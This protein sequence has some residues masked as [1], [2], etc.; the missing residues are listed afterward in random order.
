V[1]FF[2]KIRQEKVKKKKGEQ[3]KKNANLI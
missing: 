2:W 1:C 3:G